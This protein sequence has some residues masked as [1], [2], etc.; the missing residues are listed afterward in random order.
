MLVYVW[1][2]GPKGHEIFHR[3]IKHLAETEQIYMH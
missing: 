3:N 2:V 1:Y